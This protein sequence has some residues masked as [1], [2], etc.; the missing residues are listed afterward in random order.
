MVEVFL[1]A[2]KRNSNEE[3]TVIDV[4]SSC[5]INIPIKYLCEYPDGRREWVD[6]CNIKFCEIDI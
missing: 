2:T 6:E 4:E 1:K 3:F 5:D